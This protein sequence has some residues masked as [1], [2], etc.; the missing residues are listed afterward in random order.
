MSG[1]ERQHFAIPLSLA[2]VA[3]APRLVG[4]RQELEDIHSSLAGDGRRCT[5]SWWYWQDTNDRGIHE[6]A[7][8]Q[9][10]GNFLAVSHLC[11]LYTAR[12]KLVEVEDMYQRA[13]RGYEGTPDE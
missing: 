4:R 3:E 13:L 8:R 10:L 12:G 1:T 11:L 5:V 6:K 7:Q 2:G 9:L